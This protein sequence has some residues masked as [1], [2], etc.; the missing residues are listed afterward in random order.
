MSK[1]LVAV[2]DGTKARFF[3]LEPSDLP[4]YESRFKL[5]EHD[6]LSNS[7]KEVQG[8]ELWAT[9]KTGRNRGASGQSHSYDDHRENHLVEFERR[10]IQA[11]ATKISNLSQ[12][13]RV[14]ELLLIAEPQILGLMRETVIPELSKQIQV[15][16]LAKDLCYLSS[17]ELHEYLAK[18][19]LLPAVKKFLN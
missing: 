1:F 13:Y 17:N 4:E 12:V 11:I 2:I 8:E 18:K 6:G 3:T 15:S 10:F 14:Q 5:I 16:E 9:T 19:Q 7:T